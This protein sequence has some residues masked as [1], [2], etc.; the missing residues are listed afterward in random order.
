MRHEDEEQPHPKQQHR[1]VE[2]RKSIPRHRNLELN[3]TISSCLKPARYTSSGSGSVNSSDNS[4]RRN[5]SSHNG[6][7]D[8]L[9]L[10]PA[11][12]ALPIMVAFRKEVSFLHYH[13]L[14]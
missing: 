1:P 13:H 6:V 2:R 12:A 8:P 4:N 9:L 3:S 7:Q 5:S 11:A 10:P 14:T